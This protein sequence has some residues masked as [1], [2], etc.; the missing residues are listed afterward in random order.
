MICNFAT[1][2]KQ[3]Q[4]TYECFF[5]S[6]FVTTPQTYYPGIERRRNNSGHST[7]F[8]TQWQQNRPWLV[9]QIHHS[10]DGIPFEKLF[11]TLCQ[12]WDT[13]G[14]NGSTV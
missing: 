12:K 1:T 4:L 13:R 9:C 11:C 2:K 3:Q 10:P 14:E 6:S 5:F 7:V 8:N